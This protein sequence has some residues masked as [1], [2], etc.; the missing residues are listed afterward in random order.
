LWLRI[1][2][3]IAGLENLKNLEKIPIPVD[4]HI[5]RASNFLGVIKN[6][7]GSILKEDKLPK[8]YGNIRDAWSKS[9]EG[10][11]INGKEIIAL[12]MD[13]PLWLLSR[14]GCSKIDKENS[15]KLCS[16]CVVKDLCRKVKNY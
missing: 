9:V 7:D 3:D 4:V 5:A 11:N 2:R 10:L 12:D 1:L 8:C 13:E 15:K 6:N 16:D 14:Y